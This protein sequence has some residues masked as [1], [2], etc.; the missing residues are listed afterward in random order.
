MVRHMFTRCVPPLLGVA[1]AGCSVMGYPGGLSGPMPAAD[2]PPGVA[3]ALD[4][5]TRPYE[6][7]GVRYVPLASSADYREV[8]VASWY[9]EP[10][11]GRRTASGEVY[12][13]YQLTAAHRTL[14]LPT[15][16]EVTRLED[17][18][19][20]VVRVN[21]RGPFVEGRRIIDLSYSAAEAIGL[22]GP[23]TTEVEVRALGDGRGC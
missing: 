14:P 12:D 16:A 4:P 7:R 5:K 20:V 8:G 3:V 19:T 18:R 11:H 22:V 6:V 9:G 17:G 21:D 10:F 13:M 23:G 2:R 1:L 15:C